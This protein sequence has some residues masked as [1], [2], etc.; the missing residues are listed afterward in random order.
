MRK[1]F[2]HLWRWVI[3]LAMPVFLCLTVARALVSEAYLRYEYGKPDFPA[4]S[5]GFTQQQRL[6]LAT[7]S[8]QFLWRKEP[9]EQA[10]SMLTAQQLPGTD[11]PLFTRYEL[12]HMMDVKRFTDRLWRIHL[13]TA[14][15]V[16]GGLALLLSQRETHRVAFNALFGGG[17]LTAGLLLFLTAFVLLGWRTFFIGFHDLFFPPGTWTFD[18]SDSLIRLFPDRFWFDAGTIVTAGTLV[19]GV[20]I[21][22][23]GYWLGRRGARRVTSN[24]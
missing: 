22:G 21:S 16:L 8:I 9:A 20:A 3:I 14:V 15:L 12:S 10:I 6:E 7:V 1:P 13:G 5:Y 11:K 2:V 18:W 24:E 23:I 17:V 19:A 4:D